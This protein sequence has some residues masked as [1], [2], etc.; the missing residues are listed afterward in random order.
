MPSCRI[1]GVKVIPIVQRLG[2][3]AEWERARERGGQRERKV[4]S[5]IMGVLSAGAYITLMNLTVL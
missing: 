4:I 2:R 3:K 5:T 1:T